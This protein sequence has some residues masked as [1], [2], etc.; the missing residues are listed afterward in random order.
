V[1]RLG[2]APGEH[3]GEV[4]GALEALVEAR[5][6]QHLVVESSPRVASSKAM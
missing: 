1:P 4:G 5:G 6:H 3:L 2:E